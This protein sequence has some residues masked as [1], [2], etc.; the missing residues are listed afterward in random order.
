MCLCFIINSFNDK[1]INAMGAAILP[2]LLRSSMLRKPDVVV[3][4]VVVEV[5]AEGKF[6][7]R[8]SWGAPSVVRALK[9]PAL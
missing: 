2:N 9:Q 3:V 5:V 8:V 7:R 4:V 1:T 6:V